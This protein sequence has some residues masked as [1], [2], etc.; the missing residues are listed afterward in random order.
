MSMIFDI[1]N[2]LAAMGLRKEEFKEHFV[3]AKGPGGQNVNKVATCVV[4]VHKPTGIRVKC[5]EN[6]T[7]LA[8]RRTAW[9][10][11][12]VLIAKR[13]EDRIKA[14]KHSRELKRR[15]SRGR[16]RGGKEEMLKITKLNAIKKANRT[17]VTDE[18][19]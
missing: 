14:Q 5:Q 9:M 8:N 1:D 16:S 18:Q 19:E 11:I 17:K 13:N 10:Q 12:L 3:C 7:Q 6:R 2:T 15:Q 4:L